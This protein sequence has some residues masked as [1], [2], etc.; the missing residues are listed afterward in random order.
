MRFIAVILMLLLVSTNVQCNR[1]EQEVKAS[2][3]FEKI[4]GTWVLV[5]GERHGEKFTAETTKN[6]KLTFAGDALRT[7]K[8][9]D[10]SEATFTL[11]P[12]TNPKGIDL[13][14]DGSVGL[15]IYKLEGTTLTILHG[16]VDQP[17]P[18]NFEA[19]ESGELT[20]LVLQKSA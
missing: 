12:E 6:V 16:E 5:S 2:N 3:D 15:G 17:R 1:S 14:M 13:N 9:D 10:A 19:V 18:A 7:Y 8:G 20:M 11:H 4:Q